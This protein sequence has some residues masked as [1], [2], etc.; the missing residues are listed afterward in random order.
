MS[1]SQDDYRSSGRYRPKSPLPVAL[2]QVGSA[3]IG[4]ILLIIF[5]WSCVLYWRLEVPTE[6]IAV[7]IKKTGKDL[8]NDEEIAPNAD[9]KG[10]QKEILSEGV[11]WKNPY[12]WDWEIHPQ[13]QIP[14]GKL[15]V[16]ISLT[17]EDLPYGEYLAKVDPAN[18]D[19]LKGGVTTKGIV[20]TPLVPGRY[21]INPYLFKV[22]L[23]DPVII[24]SGFKGIRT[25]LAGD[26]AKNPNTLLSE[27]GK[28]GVQKEV[29]N[30]GTVYLNPY[31]EL[32]SMVDCM[33]QKFNLAVNKDMGF[34]SK[35]G[36]W[37]SLD[38]TIEYRV[39]P[40]HAAEVY[41]TY[42]NQDN[43]DDI[44]DEIIRKVITPIARSYC[45]VEGAKKSGREFMDENREVFENQFEKVMREKCMPLGIEIQRASIT[46]LFP[47]DQIAS[48]LRDRIFAT[49]QRDRFLKEIEL[50]KQ[51]QTFASQ[52]EMTKLQ[53]DL[54]KADQEVNKITTQAKREQLV[55]ITKANEQLAVSKLRLEASKDEA[56]AIKSRGLAEADIIRF[57]NIA[58]AAGWKQAVLSFGGN[59]HAYAAY[60]LNQKLAASYKKIIA[61]SADSPLMDIFKTFQDQ[62]EKQAAPEKK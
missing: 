53:P 32:I 42:N 25:N 39:M 24:P 19:P 61:N 62:P 41:V 49:Q 1:D 43:G 8:P 40:E 34:Q 60:V 56:E 26:I 27:P 6:H 35:D 22:E 7:L 50:Q 2:P 13:T 46:K 48:P 54:I 4:V 36:F 20:P 44:Q 21:S 17:G 14:Q 57:Q 45:R 9:Y 52:T 59:G 12:S 58:E 5:M 51:E 23:H 18:P 55:A 11:T 47:P 15:G 37:I 38:A 10:V 30:E 31:V 29:Y 33:S 3:I 28:R 16:L